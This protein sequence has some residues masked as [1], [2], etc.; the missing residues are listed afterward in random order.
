M[1]NLECRE[2]RK[3][4][5]RGLDGDLSPD[6]EVVL[7]AH[8]A[9]CGDCA[10]AFERLRRSEDAVRSHFEASVAN[11]TAP[12]GFWDGL[13][14][15]LEAR[16][17]RVRWR[18]KTSSREFPAAY[19]RRRRWQRCLCLRS[20]EWRCM[21]RPYRLGME[22]L[23]RCAKNWRRSGHQSWIWKPNWSNS[24]DSRY[25]TYDFSRPGLCFIGIR[26]FSPRGYGGSAG[27]GSA[28]T[29]G[30]HPSEVGRKTACTDGRIRAEDGVHSGRLSGDAQG[31]AHPE[32]QVA[33][34]AQAGRRRDERGAG[35]GIGRR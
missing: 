23:R 21:R 20:G 7:R 2:T 35:S 33:I 28:G 22:N 3:L 4:M 30:Q 11:E 19:S 16:P 8:L 6:R 1:P 24:G 15:R 18:R 5:H 9:R 13:S 17:G 10:A 34:G 26:A 12:A 27:S 25:A 31:P 32:P 29:R 14:E